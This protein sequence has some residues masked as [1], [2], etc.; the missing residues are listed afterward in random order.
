[1]DYGTNPGV[2]AIAHGLQH[3]LARAGLE[4]R[5]VF[6]DFARPDWVDVAALA[7]EGAVARTFA[8][9]VVY[10]LDPLEPAAAVAGARAAGGPA[11]TLEPPRLPPDRPPPSPN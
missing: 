5:V 3:R 4:L 1:M 11:F 8:A 10:V 9:V 6:A 7:I 2:D